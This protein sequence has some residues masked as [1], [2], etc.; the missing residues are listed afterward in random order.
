MRLTLAA[1]EPVSARS[2]VDF[3]AGRWS[4]VDHPGRAAATHRG[5]A[6]GRQDTGDRFLVSFYGSTSGGRSLDR[7]IGTI[8]TRD[9]WAVIDG[10][11]MRMLSV[12]EATR[13]MG[14][15]SDYRL[16]ADHKLAMHMLGNAVCPPVVAALLRAVQMA[17]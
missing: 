16:P 14:F 15:R 1:T 3:S 11:R 4:A 17:A 12:P 9:R 6:R 2:I 13:A 5:I 10:D 7:P 8:T